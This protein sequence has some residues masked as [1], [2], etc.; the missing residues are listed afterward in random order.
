M[1]SIQAV[2]VAALATILAI[3]AAAAPAQA[4]YYDWSVPSNTV[5]LTKANFD[6]KVNSGMW[7][8]EF[9]APW[10]ANSKKYAAAYDRA[11]TAMIPLR[12]QNVFIARV[13]CDAEE[14]LC[15]RFKV[16]GYP[17]VNLFIDGKIQ[18]EFEGDRTAHALIT[19]VNEK[20]NKH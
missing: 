16:D 9:Y 3:V 11:A 18:E 19:Y 2:L 6:A 15:D 5:Q 13:D 12:K 17:T 8:V 14:A 1:M 20:R 4:Y 7:I 10:C